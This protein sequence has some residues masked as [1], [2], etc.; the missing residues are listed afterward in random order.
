LLIGN[1]RVITVV[2]V[3]TVYVTGLENV[4]LVN[5]K[6]AYKDAFKPKDSVA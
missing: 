3:F 4:K 6:F 5:P 1:T 2:R